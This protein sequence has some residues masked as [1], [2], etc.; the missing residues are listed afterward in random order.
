MCLRFIL[1]MRFHCAFKW[2]ILRGLHCLFL[3]LMRHDLE[4]FVIIRL[5][6]LYFDLWCRSILMNSSTFVW[7]KVL[8]VNYDWSLIL[9]LMVL[10]CT[11]IAVYFNFSRNMIAVSLI[12]KFELIVPGEYFGSWRG[13]VHMLPLHILKFLVN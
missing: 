9:L 4:D 12:F 13:S 8:L 5:L 2:D 7:I 3:A 1:D 10:I 11:I 6:L